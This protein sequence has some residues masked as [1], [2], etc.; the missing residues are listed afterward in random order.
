MEYLFYQKVSRY[1]LVQ[2]DF[3]S[4]KPIVIILIYIFF[5]LKTLQ[6][7]RFSFFFFIILIAS[8][9][10]PQEISQFFC[11]KSRI[12]CLQF[13]K[14]RYREHTQLCMRRSLNHKG[15][16]LDR[17][18]HRNREASKIRVVLSLLLFRRCLQADCSIETTWITMW[19]NF[20]LSLSL[21]HFSRDGSTIPR[22]HVVA[23]GLYLSGQFISV[24]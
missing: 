9:H 21:S 23:R 12:Y 24:Q 13:L 14:L 8:S 16:Q 20:S 4:T 11:A 18:S 7:Y 1:I 10:A 2:K 5:N 3:K 22:Y 17:I 6:A 19:G 15:T